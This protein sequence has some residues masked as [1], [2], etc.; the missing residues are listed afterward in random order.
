MNLACSLGITSELRSR[1]SEVSIVL[2]AFVLR[3]L[4]RDVLKGNLG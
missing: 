3:A 2:E 4:L 1:S